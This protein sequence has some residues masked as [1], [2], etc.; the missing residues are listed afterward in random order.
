MKVPKLRSRLTKSD[1]CF[2]NTAA[3]ELVIR[4]EAREEIQR[5]PEITPLK[6]TIFLTFAL[7][8]LLTTSSYFH[9]EEPE[10]QQ[11]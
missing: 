4:Q 6:F 8:L 11:G 10:T 3:A 2:G 1:G 5:A 9:T 7:T